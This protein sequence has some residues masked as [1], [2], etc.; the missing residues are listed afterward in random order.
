LRQQVAKRAH[1]ALT[2]RSTSA[3]SLQH[4]TDKLQVGYFEEPTGRDTQGSPF[5]LRQELQRL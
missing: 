3:E 2:Y 1:D 4:H 5:K